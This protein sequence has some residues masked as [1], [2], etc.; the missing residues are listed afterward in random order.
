MKNKQKSIYHTVRIEHEM[1]ALVYRNRK[2]LRVLKEGRGRLWDF[3]REHRV[4]LVDRRDVRLQAPEL[5][6]VA[7]SGLLGDEIRV[8]DLKERERALIR[9][10]GRLSDI[11][12]PGLH[13]LW[14]GPQRLEA[15]VLC[16]DGLLLRH[17]ELDSILRLPGQGTHLE[18]WEVP[19]GSKGVLY[20]NGKVESV[21]TAGRYAAWKGRESVRLFAVDCREKTLEISGQDIMTSDRVTLR[22]NVSVVYRVED[23]ALAVR[24][25]VNAEEAIYREAQLAVRAEIGGRSLD[26][27]LA[28]KQKLG[29]VLMERLQVRAKSLGLEI[30]QAGLRDIILPGEMKEILNQVIL[31]GKKA[32]ANGIMRR[33]ETAAMRSQMNTAKLIHE[34]PTLMRLRELEVIERI[35]ENG[36][37]NIVLGEKGLAD[38][39]THLI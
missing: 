12:G 11:L 15:E 18:S 13:L 20:V 16:T 31:A 35:A 34:N 29:D 2:L 3:K 10:D 1:R 38:R 17:P 27:L 14:T 30:R 22:L 7:E 4:V 5:R 33:E 21:L 37:L 24:S 25:S 36:K 9:I 39:I 23:V 6:Q 26:E 28:E 19:E 8:L 32:E